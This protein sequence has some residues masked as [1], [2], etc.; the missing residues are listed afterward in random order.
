[1]ENKLIFYWIHSPDVNIITFS[2]V[3]ALINKMYYLISEIPLVSNMHRHNE[4]IKSEFYVE[5]CA[6][7]ITLE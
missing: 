6:Y 5:Y 3:N 7:K 2:I 1:M 4:I